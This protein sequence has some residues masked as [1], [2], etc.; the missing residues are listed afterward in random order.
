M[1]SLD[2]FGDQLVVATSVLYLILCFAIVMHI[3][4]E[5]TEASTEEY[6]V[7]IWVLV[8]MG[9]LVIGFIIFLGLMAVLF[10]GFSVQ[11]LLLWGY[12]NIISE[13]EGPQCLVLF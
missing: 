3:S 12:Y 8:L 6:L 11:L 10:L 5:I 13:D 1:D 2:G 9:I 4:N 7:W